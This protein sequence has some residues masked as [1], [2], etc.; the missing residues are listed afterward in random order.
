MKSDAITYANLESD[1][2]WT[3]PSADE[4]SN[5]MFISSCIQLSVGYHLF[6][7]LKHDLDG[8]DL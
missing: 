2:L 6:Y 4:L 8:D 3:T 5:M 7:V 1:G